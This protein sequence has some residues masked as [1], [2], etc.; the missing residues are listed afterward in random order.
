ML[1]EKATLWTAVKRGLQRKCPA[2]GEGRAFR[3]YLKIVDQCD[4]C[5]TPLGL[6]PCDDGPAYITM[7]LVG[8]IVIGPLFAL[9]FFWKY[10]LGIVI[11]ITLVALGLLTLV[12]LPFVKGGFLGLIWHH[13]LRQRR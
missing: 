13:G 7:L 8:H 5:Q 6:Y 3:A 9:D 12:V 4:H 1:P 10:P 2:C 11:P